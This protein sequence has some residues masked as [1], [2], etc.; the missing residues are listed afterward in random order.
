MKC[1]I[2]PMP[3][4]TPEHPFLADMPIG[5]LF[6]P[7]GWTATQVKGPG[8]ITKDND[9]DKQITWFTWSS[10]PTTYPLE[11]SAWGRM[12]VRALEPGETVVLENN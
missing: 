2:K 8:M 3:L 4:E 12:R 6:I 5:T 10:G 7:V 11:T 1:L 9:G